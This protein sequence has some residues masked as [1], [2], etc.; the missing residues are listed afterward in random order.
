MSDARRVQV[1]LAGFP[2]HIFK[3]DGERFFGVNSVTFDEKR[4]RAFGYGMDRAHAPR[5]RT[6]GKYTPG[7]LKIKFFKDTAITLRA[8]LKAR[9]A[10][11]R[12][13]GDVVMQ[14]RLDVDEGEIQGSIQ[15]HDVVYTG[16]SHSVE[17]SP[18]PTFEEWAFSFMRAETE[19]TTLFNSIEEP[20]T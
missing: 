8:S 15:W 19:G 14:M 16:P 11:S 2:S 4:E 18:D 1:N 3:I 20:T 13:I 6:P 5:G 10:D 12:S 17:E 9:A 7:E